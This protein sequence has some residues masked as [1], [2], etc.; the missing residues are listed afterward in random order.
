MSEPII[1]SKGEFQRRARVKKARAW[2]LYLVRFS[3]LD[4]LPCGTAGWRATIKWV[5][6]LEPRAWERLATHAG[7]HPPSRETIT[8]IVAE[9]GDLAMKH[10]IRP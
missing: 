10:A 1:H 4:V 5:L 8:Y 6:A 3:S 9:L 2:A 7:Q